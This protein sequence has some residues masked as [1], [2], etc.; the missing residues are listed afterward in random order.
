MGHESRCDNC[1]V[2]IEKDYIL[3]ING[4]EMKFDN[5]EC[6]INFAAPRCSCCNSIIMGKATKINDDIFCSPACSQL[7]GFNPFVP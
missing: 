7:S 3:F 1:E 6:A 5:F 4:T 2:S